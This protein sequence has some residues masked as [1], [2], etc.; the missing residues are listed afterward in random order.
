VVILPVPALLVRFEAQFTSVQRIAGGVTI[1][2]PQMWA[3]S[4]S[5]SMLYC[6]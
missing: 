6:A 4:H 5:A 1:L 3:Y 2:P